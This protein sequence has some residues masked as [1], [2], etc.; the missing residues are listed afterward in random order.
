MFGTDRFWDGQAQVITMKRIDDFTRILDESWQRW[1]MLEWQVAAA[2]DPRNA[3]VWRHHPQPIQVRCIPDQKSD[4]EDGMWASTVHNAAHVAIWSMRRASEPPAWFEEG[5]AS[6]VETEVRGFQKVFCVGATE[7]NRHKTSDQPKKKGG[8]NK[9]LAGEQAVFKEHAKRAIED[10]EFPE[11]RK[12]L[13][14]KLGDLG[15]A[16]VGGAIGLV[17]WLRAKDPEKFKELWKELRQA[18][19]NDDEPW[20]KVWG[21]NLIEDMEKEFKVWARTEW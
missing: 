1:G 2:K 9:D 6:V 20:R 18:P 7:V 14:M 11:M 10:N 17:T 12:F 4:A 8:G 3:G 21:W 13:K 19:K 5:V 15:P 16:E